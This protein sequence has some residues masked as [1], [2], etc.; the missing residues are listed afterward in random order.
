MNMFNRIR[1]KIHNCKSFFDEI[2]RS[3]IRWLDADYGRKLRY[4]YYKKRLKYLGDN[5]LID[6]GVFINGA[7]YI[8]IG[9]NT[10][11]DKNCILVGASKDLDLSHRYLKI[12]DNISYKG[13]RG[14]ITIGKDCH[15]SQNT[16][17]YGYG[18]ISIGDNSTLSS[19]TKVYSL[20][21]MAYNPYDRSEIISI[22]PYDGKSPTLEGPVVLANNVWVGLDCIISPGITLGNNSF[23]KSQS[24]V[25]NSFEDNAYIGG[26]PAVYIR[27]RFK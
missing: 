21:S 24:I 7:E 5:V 12:R 15:I 11:I 26:N 18:G 10:H 6:T 20:T 9:D 16:M 4:K 1:N 8:S 23:V 25:N 2:Y 17:L 13:I 3:S 27:K 22:V 19:D 14:E